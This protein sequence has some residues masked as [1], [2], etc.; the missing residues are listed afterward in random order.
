LGWFVTKAVVGQDHTLAKRTPLRVIRVRTSSADSLIA[1]GLVAAVTLWRTWVVLQWSFRQDDWFYVATAARM[2]FV[3][4]VL[5]QY[6][7]HLLTGQFVLVWFVT[8]LAP[9]NYGVAA[10]PLLAVSALAGVLMWRFLRALFGE[11]PANLV[12]LAVFLL[13]PLTLPTAIWWAAAL[14]IIPLQAFIVAALFV[15]LRYVR[16]P[17]TRHLIEVG[18]V[19]GGALLWWEKSV[20]ILPLVALFVLL[21]LGPGRGWDRVRSVVTERWRLW[22]VLG[23]ITV[24]YVAWYLAAAN[25]RSGQR[26]TV[27]QYLHLAVTTLG[28]TAIP[29]YLGGPWKVTDR[30]VSPSGFIA[31]LGPG[32]RLLALSAGVAIIGVS[33]VLYRQAWCGWLLPLAYVGLS[34]ALVAS[35]RL[36]FAGYLIGE[37][38]RYVADSVAVVAVGVALAFMVPLDRVGD[39]GWL[40]RRFVFELGFR[41][42]ANGDGDAAETSSAMPSNVGQSV[43]GAETGRR[44]RLRRRPSARAVAVAAVA[45]YA[46]SSMT[47]NTLLAGL[48]AKESPKA[49]LGTVRSQLDANPTAAIVDTYLPAAVAPAA[50]FPQAAKD[51]AALGPVAPRIRW[52][53]AADQMMIFDSSG[54]LRPVQVAALTRGRPGPVRGCGYLVF[55]APQTVPLQRHLF[56]WV[57]GISF[58]YYTTV[59]AGGFVTVDGERQPVTF[60]RGLH[61]MTL[62][63]HGTASSVTI[64]GGGV[65][66]CVGSVRAGYLRPPSP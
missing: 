24:P 62:V 25:W 21:F 60:H 29:S 37:A 20:L 58:G 49:W 8:R 3:Q 13:C 17:S 5:Q 22:A 14:T 16:Q 36:R 55:R 6:R 19:Y 34:E 35:E 45:L 64:E 63:H 38:A 11:R 43:L 12:P 61:V 26:P 50:V 41:T 27:G 57:W 53:G 39:P 51:S 66:V 47:T 48:S 2:P 54:H 52:N 33:L 59:D 32:P 9:L 28:S 10:I 18:A 15:V 4:F 40:R 44:K 65:P 1:Y 7:G 56:A 31:Q 42:H 30:S 23:G 46:V